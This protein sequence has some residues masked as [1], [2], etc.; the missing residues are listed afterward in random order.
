MVVQAQAYCLLCAIVERNKRF[1]FSR[2]V[3]SECARSARTQLLPKVDP[4][5]GN[6]LAEQTKTV[7]VEGDDDRLAV[8]ERLWLAS[9]WACEPNIEDAFTMWDSVLLESTDRDFDCFC[10]AAV[11]ASLVRRRDDILRTDTLQDF[12][13]YSL[14]FRRETVDDDGAPTLS[15]E[16]IYIRN[17]R[18]RASSD[19]EVVSFGPGPLG[20]LLTRKRRGLVVSNFS[21]EERRAIGSPQ[22]ADTL[23]A[24][25]GRSL[26]RNATLNDAV[27]LLGAV[28]RPV[29]VA[30]RRARPEDLAA[31][32]VDDA[33]AAARRE[34]QRQ[35]RGH[36]QQPQHMSAATTTAHPRKSPVTSFVTTLSQ[37]IEP[38]PGSPQQFVQGPPYYRRAPSSP[39]LSQQRSLGSE[40]ILQPL[41]TPPTAPDG[42]KIRLLAGEVAFAHVSCIAHDVAL[43]DPHRCGSLASCSFSGEL[44]CTSYRVIFHVVGSAGRPSWAT[45]RSSDWHMCALTCTVCL[46]P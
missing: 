35:A 37:A 6:Y 38:S 41:E 42:Y 45:A 23:I 44:Y 43:V 25:N 3:C 8:A 34:Q 10:A 26:P 2:E 30:F 5:L 9:L 17:P 40:P 7:A 27:A 14:R 15:C 29:L 46:P 20:I 39:T 31:D 36:Q 4:E 1:A 22:I 24:V 13:F 33:Q 16:A 18:A 21:S 19:V 32:A 28:G 12:T 11:C